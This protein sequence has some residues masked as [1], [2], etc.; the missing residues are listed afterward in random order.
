MPISAFLNFPGNC[1][2]A[3]AFYARVFRLPLPPMIPYG[4][5]TSDSDKSLVL[6][7]SLAIF[8]SD[9]MFCD[10]SAAAD[11]ITG[12][13]FSLTIG[14]ADGDEL[15][16]VFDELSHGGQVS[17]PP[18]TTFWSDWFARVTDKYGIDWQLSRSQ[19]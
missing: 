5:P 4:D 14:S 16:R 18:Q 10:T 19:S 9:V 7:A 17:M 13:N 8:G 2:E 6:Y 3:V 11:H 12:N 1:R 15:R